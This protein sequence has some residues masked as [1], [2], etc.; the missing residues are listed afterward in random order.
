MIPPHIH[1][2]KKSTTPIPKEFLEIKYIVFVL[3]SSL[4]DHILFYLCITQQKN[5]IGVTNVT[6]DE[7]D[8]K[9]N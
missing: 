5:L 2:T 9:N 1:K 4:N 6:N 8:K 7:A 3:I